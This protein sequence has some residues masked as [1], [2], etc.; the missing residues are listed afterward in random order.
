M[1]MAKVLEKHI[2]KL[3]RSKHVDTVTVSSGE[4]NTPYVECNRVFTTKDGRK[5]GVYFTHYIEFGSDNQQGTVGISQD[6]MML[7]DGG[8]AKLQV[9]TTQISNQIVVNTP[10]AF[11]D[12]LGYAE[13]MV[14]MWFKECGIDLADVYNYK[15][16]TNNSTGIYL[17]LVREFW[18]NPNIVITHTRLE[19]KNNTNIYLGNRATSRQYGININREGALIVYSKG[20]RGEEVIRQ[21][22]VTMQNGSNVE[23]VIDFIKTC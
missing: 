15:E 6:I 9:G 14:F 1:E 2:K 18:S 23:K 7:V 5:V 20:V 17:A 21:H 19:G 4:G 16:V 22:V 3:I 8:V 12:A 13:D 11:R 10:D